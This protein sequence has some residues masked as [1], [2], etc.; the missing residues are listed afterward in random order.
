MLIPA[1]D[2]LVSRSFARFTRAEISEARERDGGVFEGRWIILVLISRACQASNERVGEEWRHL[3]C[4]AGVIRFPNWVLPRLWVVKRDF[5][6]WEDTTLLV[7]FHS[8]PVIASHQRWERRLLRVP[9]TLYSLNTPP[10][11]FIPARERLEQ[12]LYQNNRYISINVDMPC[13]TIY[14]LAIRPVFSRTLPVAACYLAI[15][16]I[17]IPRGGWT[18]TDQKL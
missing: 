16:C 2:K 15:K 14:P 1:R 6:D 12:L 13:N 3:I 11:A 18:R 8:P 9:D 10:K 5:R 4:R 17:F 7:S